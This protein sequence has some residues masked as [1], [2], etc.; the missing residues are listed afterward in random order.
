[1]WT[2]I[3][4]FPHSARRRRAAS[5]GKLR[6]LSLSKCRVT[7]DPLGLSGS[8]ELAEVERQAGESR[9]SL[10]LLLRKFLDFV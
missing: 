5:F 8:T 2:K 3:V 7:L 4:H 6:I 1:M 10:L 9:G